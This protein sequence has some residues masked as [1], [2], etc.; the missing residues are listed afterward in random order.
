VVSSQPESGYVWILIR[1]ADDL[2]PS[3]IRDGFFRVEGDEVIVTTT[4]GDF[5][6][7]QPLFPG[8]DPASLARILLRGIE[9]SSSG[10]FNRPIRRQS[11]GIA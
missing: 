1:Q 6:A 2:D 5:L 4:S 9:S 7:S 10:D 11:W 8:Q 3:E